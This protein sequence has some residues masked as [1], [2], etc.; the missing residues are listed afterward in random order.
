MAIP[1]VTQ[2]CI[3]DLGHVASLQGDSQTWAE[4][5]AARLNIWASTLGVFSRGRHSLEYRL[6]LNEDMAE[7]LLQILAGLSDAIVS[8]IEMGEWNVTTSLQVS[9][10]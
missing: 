1:R 8:Y 6:R 9:S 3:G 4:N 5:Q 2:K 10:C 7:M